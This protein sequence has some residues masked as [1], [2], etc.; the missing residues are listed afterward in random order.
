MV[1]DEIT[2]GA[3]V[4]EASNELHLCYLY[5]TVTYVYPFNNANRVCSQTVSWLYLPK[6]IFI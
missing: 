5:N 3:A 1:Y 2:I 4:I 6:V